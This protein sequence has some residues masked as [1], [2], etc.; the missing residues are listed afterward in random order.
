MTI[1]HLPLIRKLGSFP[2][3][4]QTFVNMNLDIEKKIMCFQRLQVT[5]PYIQT[6][7]YS[8]FLMWFHKKLLNFSGIHGIQIFTFRWGISNFP[9]RPTLEIWAMKPNCCP[10]QIQGTQ[11]EFCWGGFNKN[12][13]RAPCFFFECYMYTMFIFVH[14][15]KNIYIYIHVYLVFL[16]QIIF[17]LWSFINYSGWRCKSAEWCSVLTYRWL[18]EIVGVFRLILAIYKTLQNSYLEEV[19]WLYIL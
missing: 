12:Q 9:V 2:C 13:D 8:D 17:S 10:D 19:C 1:R 18:Q 4:E 5:K 7:K 16:D 15:S 3:P 11:V 14:I 6:T